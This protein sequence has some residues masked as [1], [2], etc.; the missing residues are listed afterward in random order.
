[1]TRPLSY[2]SC[3]NLPSYLLS[4]SFLPTRSSLTV[5]SLLEMW[6]FLLPQPFSHHVCSACRVFSP[7]LTWPGPD[8]SLAPLPAGH[9]LME[10]FPATHSNL[11]PLYITPSTS[12]HHLSHILIICISI[13]S[14]LPSLLS[15]ELHE[16]THAH[17]A[18][19]SVQ[20]SFPKTSTVFGI[21]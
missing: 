17:F 3:T 15:C 4:P 5:L 19:D 10:A 14:H 18:H 2:A 20:P 7:H 8:S 6:P 16:G 11:G 1:M 13:I 12:S 21:L 9:F